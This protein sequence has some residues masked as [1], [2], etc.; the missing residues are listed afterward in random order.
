MEYLNI[1][2]KRTANLKAKPEWKRKVEE[3]WVGVR[4][5]VG[6]AGGRVGVGG[7]LGYAEGAYVINSP[8]P[9]CCMSAAIHLSSEFHTST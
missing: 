2:F 4:G 7:W 9:K 6:G 5:G 3:G 8:L 1:Q